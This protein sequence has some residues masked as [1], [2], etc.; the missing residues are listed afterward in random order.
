MVVAIFSQHFCRNAYHWIPLTPHTQ[1]CHPFVARYAGPWIVES[2]GGDIVQMVTIYVKF[3]TG[4]LRKSDLWIPRTPQNQIPRTP[5]NQIWRM[6]P[7]VARY[8]GSRSPNILGGKTVTKSG[9]V[10]VVSELLIE[11]L[12]RRQRASGGMIGCPST[13]TT[14]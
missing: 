1:L 8:A 13:S 9:Y 7:F 3:V 14:R 11:K 5:Q 10:P 2:L 6:Y 12:E 4:T